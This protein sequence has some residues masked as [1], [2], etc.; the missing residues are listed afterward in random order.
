MSS[1]EQAG[2]P[3]TALGLLI[4][5][6]GLDGDETEAPLGPG[7]VVGQG[8]VAE[9]AV[10]IGEVVAHGGHHEAVGHRHRAD[11]HGREHIRKFHAVLLFSLGFQEKNFSRTSW[12]GI[13]L[14][15][16]SWNAATPCHSSIP[17]PPMARPAARRLGLPDHPGLPGVVDGVRHHQVRAE[18][19]RVDEGLAVQG[20]HAHL[21]GVHQDAATRHRLLQGGAVLQR[22]EGDLAGRDG[23]GQLLHRVL[24]VGI[25]FILPVEDGDF[26]RA[27]QGRLDA[28]GGGGAASAQDHQFLAP[29][30]HAVLPEVADKADAVGV[31]S[32]EAAVLPHGDGV[33]GADELGG[34]GQRVHDPS[35][36]GLVRH[37]DVEAARSQGL[38]GGHARH[39]LLQ[40]DVE[41][42]IGGI[43]AGAGKAVI[44][45]GRGPGVAHRRADQ[46]VE[47]GVS[48]NPAFYG[49]LPP[50]ISPAPQARPVPARPGQPHS[51]PLRPEPHPGLKFHR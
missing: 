19:G 35:Y 45:H 28:D 33:A 24:S 15:V 25:E 42:Q 26:R 31:V 16:N 46:A 10:R 11:A 49:S 30:L 23:L 32:G 34:R 8:A 50:F 17:M 29:D 40:G 36:G 21:G 18:P 38:Q 27:V 43:H 41:G 44:V 13:S 39:R 37:G 47:L 3:G 2:F 22:G 7:L 4:D 1:G 12:A 20:L 6:G 51:C 5:H 9:R 14:P 48:G